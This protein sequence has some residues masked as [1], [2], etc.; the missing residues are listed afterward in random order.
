MADSPSRGERTCQAILAAAYALFLEHGYHATSMR[1]IAQRA[2]LALGGIYNHFESK[3][4]IFETVLLEKHPYRRV[5]EILKAA[6]GDSLEQFAHEAAR[7]MLAELGDRPDLLKLAFIELSEFQGKHVARLAQIVFPE[8]APLLQRF[9]DRKNEL[10]DLPM[11]VV[12]VAFIGAF[13]SY[14]LIN[15]LIAPAANAFTLEEAALDQVIDVILHG[16]LNP[17]KSRSDMSQ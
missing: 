3:E 2:G 5:V 16:L 15:N 10:R 1:Q 13:L 9:K 17:I 8:I 6:P 11:P 14:F 12:I 4:Q 7:A